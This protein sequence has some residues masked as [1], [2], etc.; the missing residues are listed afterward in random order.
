MAKPPLGHTRPASVK[1]VI[2]GG[3]GAGKTTLVTAVSD[4]DVITTETRITTASKET[5]DLAL[6]PGKQSTTVAMDFGR[7]DLESGIHLYLFGTPGQRRFWFMWTQIAQGALGAVVLADPRRLADCFSAVD[8]FEH[9][10]LPYIVVINP[11]DGANAYTVEQLR[12]ALAVSPEVPVVVCDARSR[13]GARD[14]L[15]RLVEYLIEQRLA[16][17]QLVAA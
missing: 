1:V 14:V 13:P 17:R 5:D 10:R 6:V 7:V 3:F 9:H 16:G 11:F 8:F 2:A 15:I 4:I 12:T